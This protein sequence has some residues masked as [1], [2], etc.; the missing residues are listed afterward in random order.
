MEKS[1][2]RTQVFIVPPGKIDFITVVG[3][4]KLLYCSLSCFRV[5]ATRR[6][7]ALVGG[8]GS[9]G[10]CGAVVGEGKGYN[11]LLFANNL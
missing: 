3:Y 6:K 4:V 10:G 8:G 5:N 2:N 7:G 1:S 11:C 9:G